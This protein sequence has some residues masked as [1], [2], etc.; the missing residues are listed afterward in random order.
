MKKYKEYM[1]NVRASDTLHQR[2]LGLEASGKRPIP[3]KRYGTMAAAL[4]L[5]VG[6]GTWWLSR[7]EVY[8]PLLVDYGPFAPEIADE[9]VPDIALVEAGDVTEPGMKTI[10]GYEVISGSG[11]NAIAAYCM[12]PYIEYG[13]PSSGGAAASLVPPAG[14]LRETTRDDV[15]ALVGGED[16]LTAHLN[17]G[18]CELSGT[19]GFEADGTVWMMSLWG[20]GADTAFNLE[21]SP[22]RMPPTCCVVIG[23]KRTITDVWGVEVSGVNSAGAY[24]DTERGVYMDVSREVEFIA[25]G[26]GCR[27]KVYGTQDGAV[28]E[29]ASRFVRWAVLEGLDLSGISQGVAKPLETD[30]NYSVGEPNYEDGVPAVDPDEAMCS[31]YPVPEG[32]YTCP[33]CGQTVPVGEKHYHTQDGTHTCD[34]CGEAVPEGMEH[35]HEPCGLPLAPATHVCEVCGQTIQDGVEHSHSDDHHD[36]HHGSHH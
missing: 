5:V 26:V 32:G 33:D 36:N 19:V 7:E 3:W 14:G 27:L 16:A 18:G 17:W 30:P 20:K 25:K 21:L 2:L 23:E 22:D 11:D 6:L 1:D 34:V 31:G 10:G 8:D 35:S 28:E 15:L 4:A 13:P 9:P 12:L 24:G 29:L